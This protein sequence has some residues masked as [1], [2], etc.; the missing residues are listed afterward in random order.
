MS[1]LRKLQGKDLALA[2]ELNEPIYYD[3]DAATQ[4]IKN[5][6]IEEEVAERSRQERL[7]A[8]LTIEEQI[9]GNHAQATN[10]EI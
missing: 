8:P 2:Y 3:S 5:Q 9:F 1:N 10:T 6:I 7:N 4:R